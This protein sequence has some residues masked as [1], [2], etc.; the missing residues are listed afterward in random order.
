VVDDC[1][2]ATDS[3]AN[4]CQLVQEEARYHVLWLSH[5]CGL[6]LVKFMYSRTLT[7]YDL[8]YDNDCDQYLQCSAELVVICVRRHPEDGTL[9][10]KHV[11][12]TIIVDCFVICVL[13]YFIECVCLFVC[14]YIEY[15]TIFGRSNMERRN[16][17]SQAV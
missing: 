3:N 7:L 12:G 8:K 13:L 5:Q 15:K 2:H 16:V 14:Q 10:P 11:V 4:G 9:V 6:V 17:S 1:I